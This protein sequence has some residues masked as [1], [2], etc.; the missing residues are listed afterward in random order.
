LRT[1]NSGCDRLTSHLEEPYAAC[2]HASE[3]IFDV[4]YAEFWTVG[5]DADHVEPQGIEAWCS[6]VEVVF[7]YGADGVLLAG[8]DGFQRVSEA[9]LP[10]QLDFHEDERV[11]FADYQVDLPAPRPVVAFEEYVTGLDQVAQGEVFAP[12]A[13][14]FVF[15][16]PTPA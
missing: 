3:S 16:S 6:R 5:E 15:Q 14:G 1:R 12:C 11:V 9:G 7:G 4:M 13:G 2:W 10:S 8:G